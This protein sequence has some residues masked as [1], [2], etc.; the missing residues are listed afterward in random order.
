MISKAQSYRKTSMSAAPIVFIVL[1][2]YSHIVG[3]PEIFKKLTNLMIVFFVM[4]YF[5]HVGFVMLNS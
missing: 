3:Y 5:S 1:L 4:G 2:D